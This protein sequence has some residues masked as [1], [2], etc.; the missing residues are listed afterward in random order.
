MKI[1]L[2]NEILKKAL[3]LLFVVFIYF[4][5]TV[6]SQVT[7]S[8]AKIITSNYD[9][10]NISCAIV[11][12]SGEKLIINKLP[13]DIY[14]LNNLDNLKCLG[15]VV[16]IFEEKNEV[17][18]YYARNL[19]IN[20]LF[21]FSL[22]IIFIGG[23]LVKKRINFFFFICLHQFLYFVFNFD[24]FTFYNF[25]LR[26]VTINLIYFSILLIFDKKFKEFMHKIIQEL[27]SITNKKN[28]FK[29]SF[30]K[31][32]PNLFSLSILFLYGFFIGIGKY[33][34]KG[35]YDYFNDEL[36][37]VFTA[38]KMNYFDLSTIS[39]TLNHHSPINAELFE[40]IFI[41]SH[42][43]KFNIGLILLETISAFLA[44]ALLLFLLNKISFNS[45]LSLIFSIVYLTFFST[46][47]LLN[48]MI[49]QI[50]YLLIFIFILNYSQSRNRITLFGIAFFSILQL[51]NMES[52]LPTM[53]LIF[54]YLITDIFTN[55]KEIKLTVLFSFLSIGIIYARFFINEE[56]KYLLESNY[57][58][59]L[60]NTNKYF[61]L[62]V[63]FGSIGQS[64]SFS[65]KHL[66]FYLLVIRIFFLLFEFIKNKKE[67]TFLNYEKLFIFIFLGEL[68]HLLLTGPRSEH[69]GLVLVLPMLILSFIYIDHLFSSK[70]NFIAFLIL[71]I[72]VL[73]FPKNFK[74]ASNNF[75]N[76]SQT[77][78]EQVVNTADEKFILSYLDVDYSLDPEPILVWIH[79]VDW[80]FAFTSLNSLPATKYWFWFFMKYYQTDKYTWETNWDEE[81][82]IQDFYLDVSKEK[83]KFAII[84]KF[85]IKYP[86]FFEELLRSN[87]NIIFDGEEYQLY[88]RKLFN[89]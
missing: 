61:D 16:Q 23:F 11:D 8:E 85:M 24:I 31:N 14:F 63:L 9:Q 60:F 88:E 55:K 1:I 48:R 57:L 73:S 81:K 83:P 6:P 32:I 65:F 75:T 3:A 26:I 87:Y 4:A 10:T 36:I 34:S 76:R 15:R 80:N 54:I 45:V 39:S 37:Q 17:T 78:I 77:E 7:I 79:P 41:F 51:Y 43:S 38:A 49:G 46:E 50:L 64:Q 74:H 56:F 25:L 58:F 5:I 20:N 42:F 30:H 40:L 68:V 84:D 52:Y 2:Q 21:N 27:T 19:R 29:F 71:L 89:N 82:I 28:I 18:I 70:Y 53:L 13:R 44:S 59:H 62:R 86:D 35:E 67:F 69:Y 12:T 33:K 22:P 47:L 72:F 66:I